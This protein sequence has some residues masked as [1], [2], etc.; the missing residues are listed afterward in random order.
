LSRKKR[1]DV[2]TTDSE[3]RTDYTKIILSQIILAVVEPDDVSDDEI[4]AEEEG[5]ATDAAATPDDGRDAHDSAI[6]K[7]T[8]D[9][10][11]EMMRLDG[12]VID[13]EEN[14]MALQLFPRVS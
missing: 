9:M 10:A 2:T 7:T 6:I 1:K 5:I 4:A 13:P 12:V 3:F 11:I 14:K 8:R